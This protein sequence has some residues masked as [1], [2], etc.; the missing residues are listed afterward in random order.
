MIIL[1]WW[2]S[3]K[4]GGGVTFNA[5]ILTSRRNCHYVFSNSVDQSIFMRTGRQKRMYCIKNVP[6]LFY[7]MCVAARQACS[8]VAAP[9]SELVQYSCCLQRE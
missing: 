6:V 7:E 2:L 9:H 3:E 8:G 1:F 4:Q 5:Q